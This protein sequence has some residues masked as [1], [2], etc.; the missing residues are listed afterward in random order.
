[1]TF[2][3]ARQGNLRNRRRERGGMRAKNIEGATALRRLRPLSIV[4]LSF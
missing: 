4:P 3:N 1:M 2:L